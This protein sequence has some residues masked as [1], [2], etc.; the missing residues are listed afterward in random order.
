[1]A[2]EINV[3]D[4]L[5]LTDW[6][7]QTNC[8]ISVFDS[9]DVSEYTNFYHRFAEIPF[10][11]S[12]PFMESLSFNTE[13]LQSHNRTEQRIAKRR[14]MPDRYF[15]VKVILENSADINKFEN[16]IQSSL[17]QQ[18]AF[19]FWPVAESHSGTINAGDTSITVDT[20]YA[21]YRMGGY[22]M[23]WEDK[24]TYDIVTIASFND[25]TLYLNKTPNNTYTSDKYIVPVIP[26][27]CVSAS[28]IAWIQDRAFFNITFRVTDF[29]DVIDYVPGMTYDNHIVLKDVPIARKGINYGY[30][31]DIA[32]LETG[33]GVFEIVSNS[34]YNVVSQPYTW[35][36]E[37]KQASWELRQL[38]HLINGQ[39]KGLLVP[40]YRNDLQ[41][42]Q[43]VGSGDTEIY[44]VNSNLTYDMGL[45]D[46][47][48]YIA[49][50]PTGSDIIVRKVTDI[51]YVD[52]TEEKLVIDQSPGQSFDANDYICWVDMC[53]LSSP[54]INIEWYQ[55]GKCIIE[56]VLTR[57]K[58]YTDPIMEPYVH[59]DLSLTD[60]GEMNREPGINVNESITVTEDETVSVI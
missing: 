58:T 15:S 37:S 14:G 28:N 12:L 51:I 59:D 25:T 4:T 7:N 31:P 22:A 49:F 30:S 57:V 19:P 5:S 20:T 16:R 41:L 17:K 18:W 35:H 47:R 26:A 36:K 9:I 8:L 34:D 21:G 27:R 43:A 56:A 6:S 38:L 45:N 60:Y 46:M 44:I 50:R 3:N 40:T 2:H 13:I 54:N 33:S 52:S 29:V 1:M 32:I 53:R 24:D 10:R 42:S 23:I 11:M 39:Q 55:R 48:T